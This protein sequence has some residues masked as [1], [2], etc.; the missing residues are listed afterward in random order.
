MEIVINASVHKINTMTNRKV[1]E[2]NHVGRDFVIGDLH[3]SYTAFQN[4]LINIGFDKSKD[5]IISVGDLVDRGP[6]SYGCLKL[7]N[8]PWFHCVRANHELMMIASF[9]GRPEAPYWMSNG[10]QWGA[11]HSRQFN[12]RLE[13]EESEFGK[14]VNKARNLP[15]LITLKKRDG[16]QVHVIHAEFPLEVPITDEDLEN[17]D[18]LKDIITIRD[19]HGSFFLWGRF[20]FLDFYNYNLNNIKKISRKVEYRSLKYNIPIEDSKLSHVISGH[21]IIHHPL[22]IGNKTCI[23]TAAYDSYGGKKNN[24][25]KKVPKWC[26][27]T[28]ID[29]NA[30]EFHQAT[31]NTYKIVK[32]IVIDNEVIKQNSVDGRMF[33]GTRRFDC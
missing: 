21:T 2:A 22:T 6:D 11:F 10:G 29:V 20:T 18:F 27:L 13:F 32:P 7:L 19:R 26:A 1:L 15:Y 4:L 33:S 9:Y 23:D 24:K 8:E 17:D 5:R 16:T 28:A 14:L 3:G 25:Y 12:S 30:W 31:E